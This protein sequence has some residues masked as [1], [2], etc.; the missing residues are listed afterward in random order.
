MTSENTHRE[1]LAAA[2]SAHVSEMRIFWRETSMSCKWLVPESEHCYV[3]KELVKY[4]REFSERA[5]QIENETV[6]DQWKSYVQPLLSDEEPS[7]FP[8]RTLTWLLRVAESPHRDDFSLDSWSLYL[9]NVRL[10]DLPSRIIR[11]LV[12][13]LESQGG[14]LNVIDLDTLITRFSISLA[15]AR[16]QDVEKRSQARKM[17]LYQ[18]FDRLRRFKNLIFHGV[19]NI[20]KANISKQL[21]GEWKNMTGREIGAHCVTVFHSH[22][23]Y[24]DMIERRISGGQ[25]PRFLIDDGGDLSSPSVWA[26]HIHDAKYFFEYADGDIQE[27]L[28]LALCRA[29]AHNPDKDY[30]F[31]IDCIDEARV[32][33]VFGEV[34]H[35]LDSFARVPWK[36]TE[37]GKGAWDL[38]VAGARSIRLTH[39]GRI[40]FVPSNVYVLGTANEENIWKNTV[41]SRIIQTFA[42]EHL[43]AMSADELKYEMLA[44]RDSVEFARLE[45]YAEHSVELWDKLNAH[46]LQAGGHRNLIGYGPLLSMCEEILNSSD[47]QDANRIVLGT[48]RYRMLPPLIQKMEQ[49]LVAC[50]KD[51]LGVRRS[52]L[53]QLIEVLNQS[54]LRISVAIEG[55]VPCES[56]SVKFQDNFLL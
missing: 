5:D 16:P 22:V 36:N 12:V 7:P 33:D 10:V 49:L 27:G 15:L 51:E 38:E 26:P 47:V 37:D 11:K 28:F 52:I 13:Y 21:I 55:L 32:S 45:E 24:E 39:S 20:G 53:D 44:Y 4:L 23:S 43:E 17:A 2:L 1:V 29:A 48:W 25:Q 14:K 41:D 56:I 54:W 34:A 30:V 46:L 40:F 6:R 50:A 18:R 3:G 9:W 31:M 42:L 8:L 35:M 19:S